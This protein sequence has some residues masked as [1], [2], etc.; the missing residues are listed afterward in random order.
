MLHTQAV[1]S[2]TL[3]ILKRLMQEEALRHFY[4]VGR[5]ALSLYISHRKSIDL[6][7]FTQEPFDADML[8]TL[9]VEKYGL[10]N[11]FMRKNT[12]KGI[13]SGVKIDCITY[14]Y[15]YIDQACEEDGIRICG[16]KDIAAMK[17]SAIA[18][19]GS[20]LKDFVD[21]ACLSTKF[22]LE[23]MLNVYGEKYKEMNAISPLKALTY[24]DDIQKREPIQVL[25]GSF[26]WKL[27][28]ERLRHMIENIDKVY[29]SYPFK[30]KKQTNDFGMHVKG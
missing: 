24:Y 23:T 7:L 26:D 12:I 11:I 17:L 25:N 21:I 2:G 29:D 27:I 14:N 13:I 15:P 6:A 4:L 28:E 20:R 10:S 19:S 30:E 9:F 5:T 1:E 18:D 3:E 22:S 16:M 8:R